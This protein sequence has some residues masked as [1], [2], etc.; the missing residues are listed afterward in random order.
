MVGMDEMIQ[1]ASLGV[2]VK[3]LVSGLM[4]DVRFGWKSATRTFWGL[5]SG[6]SDNRGCETPY[7]QTDFD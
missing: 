4:A 3:T 2:S 6:E 1:A 7:I 5:D